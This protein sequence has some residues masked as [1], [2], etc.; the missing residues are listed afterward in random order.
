MDDAQRLFAWRTDPV[1]QQFSLTNGPRNFEAHCAWLRGV[2]GDPQRILWIAETQGPVGT[3]R[4][5]FHDGGWTLSWTV[6]PEARGQGVG[7]QMVQAAV[8]RLP[9]KIRAAIHHENKASQTIAIR[10]GFLMVEDTDTLTNWETPLERRALQIGIKLWSTNHEWFLEAIERY[11]KKEYDFLELYVAP[12][13]FH[14]GALQQLHAAH[15]PIVIHAANETHLNLMGPQQANATRLRE[16]VTFAD[17]FH[18]DTIVLHPGFGNDPRVFQQHL[19]T[20]PDARYMIENVPCQALFG[21]PP[22]YGYNAETLAPLLEA[23]HGRFCLDFAHAAKSA[24]SLGK[25]Y[26]EQ[27][28]EFMALHPSY[29]HI[30]GCHVDRAA[31]EHLDLRDSELDTAWCKSLI[32]NHPHPR[33]ALETPKS[34][35]TLSNDIHNLFDFISYP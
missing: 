2:L 17:F 24:C 10:S 29:F 3:I 31:D 30:T 6:A 22:L 7:S 18:A 23:T 19:T 35:H 8:A 16:A 15:I 14:R 34:G 9:G 27:I 33:I 1:T 28:T 4:A 26:R 13:S 32:L 20:I 21:L 11:E 12:E 5:D 25:S